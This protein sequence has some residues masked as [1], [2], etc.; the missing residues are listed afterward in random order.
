MQLLYDRAVSQV[1][2]TLHA[3]EEMAGPAVTSDNLSAYVVTEK[4]GYDSYPERTRL[5]FSPVLCYGA[6]ISSID[7]TCAR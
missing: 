4:G 7:F 1:M 2:W 3:D 5:W 6:R